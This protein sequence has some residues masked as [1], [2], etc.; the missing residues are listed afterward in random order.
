MEIDTDN[1]VEVISGNHLPL[2]RIDAPSWFKRDDFQAYVRDR[3]TATWHDKT[4]NSFDDYSDVF[5]TFSDG[6][7]SD[8]PGI[9]DD[10]W[11]ELEELIEKTYGTRYIEIM[12]WVANL[13]V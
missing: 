11:A 9:P 3:R 4:S 1:S 7:G 5:F 2:M 10:I 8:F 13:P 12:V 6:G